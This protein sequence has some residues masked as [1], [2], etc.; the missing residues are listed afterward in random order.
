MRTKTG[1][2]SIK[3]SKVRTFEYVTHPEM[4]ALAKHAGTT[5]AELWTAF[6]E[7]NFIIAKDRLAAEHVYSTTKEELM[8]AKKG[9]G[10]KAKPAGKKKPAGAMPIKKGYK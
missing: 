8:A 6:K 4:A 1:K 2:L 3:R 5:Q 7:R 9:K 10:G